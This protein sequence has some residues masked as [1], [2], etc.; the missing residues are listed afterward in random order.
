MG[1][2]RLGILPATQQWRE[3]LALLGS[4][5]ASIS[6]IVD[7]ISEASQ[8]SFEKASEDPNFLL[9]IELMYKIPKAAL[10]GKNLQDALSSIGV[11]IP[12]DPTQPDLIIGIRNAFD[13]IQAQRGIEVNDLGEFAK[14]AV[15]SVFSSFLSKPA[16]NAQLDLFGAEIKPDLQWALEG[17]ASPEGFMN[18]GQSFFANMINQNTLYFTDRVTPNEIGSGK[19][20]KSISHLQ[21]FEKAVQRHSMEASVIVRAAF[22]D[23]YAKRTYHTNTP[24]TQKDY[25]GFTWLTANKV[26]KEIRAR[27]RK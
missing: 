8:K 18:L 10:E 14:N 22:R 25:K 27:N 26:G 1:H 7:K 12:T 9:A 17:L 6:E 15:A 19:P 2:Q 20:I 13:K 3:I 5:Q 24:L 4:D 11:S 23:W 16:P 21:N